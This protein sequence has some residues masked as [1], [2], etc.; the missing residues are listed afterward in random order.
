MCAKGQKSLS[1]LVCGVALGTIVMVANAAK[2]DGSVAG[3][4]AM[5]A[6]KQALHALNRL[7]FGPRPGEVQRVEE[8]GVDKWIE[9]QLH[10]EKLDDSALEARLAPF[11]T[12]RM[13]TR[14]LVENFPPPQMIRAVADGRQ[15]L[16]SN[17]ATRAIY[18]AQMER[19][20]QKDARK[21]RTADPNRDDPTPNTAASSDKDHL[22]VEDDPEAVSRWETARNVDLKLQ[23]LLELPPDERMRAI[24]SMSPD[25]Q[26]ALTGRKS[27]QRQELMEGM[28]PEQKE[29]LS[30]INNPGQVVTSELM[31]AKLL[32]AIYSNRQLEEV[33][34]AFWFNHFNIF[35]NN[36]AD[37]YLVTSYERDVIR[38]HALG[39]FE[40]LLVATAKSPAMLLY[41]DNWVSVGPDSDFAQG[42]AKKH[43]RARQRKRRFPRV[44]HAPGAQNGP[45]KQRRGLNENYARELMELHTLGV[46]G[47]YIQQDVTEVAR[48]L[49]G[50]TIDQPKKGGEF[51]FEARM[52]EPCAKIVLGHKI[53][54]KGE[55]EGLEVLHLL[56]RNPATAR[57]ISSKLAS[58]FVSDNPP[59]ALV[60]RM[61]ETF[62]KKNGDIRE[63]LRTMFRSPEFWSSEAYRAKV[64][65]PLEF[66][67]SAARG[68]DADIQDA[69]ALVR[70]LNTMGMLPYGMQPPT[71]YSTNAQT[72]V[73]S[74][75]LVSRMNFAL[76]LTS[77][78]LKG[79]II[80]EGSNS[81]DFNDPETALK[82]S[83]SALL[84]GDVSSQTHEAIAKQIN[85]GAGS[86]W[87]QNGPPAQK[88][89]AMISGLILGSP[90]FQ[91]R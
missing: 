5:D 33:M 49:T 24:L 66:I 14:E 83:E 51:K 23:E 46:D 44:V 52:H 26:L 85:N 87:R 22:N 89:S 73:T 77:G 57:H 28:S 31:Q 47:G 58:R 80:S 86:K 90:E 53:K 12:L 19:H 11:R 32:R 72:W 3:A 70:I 79:I 88:Q 7:A 37:R 27:G 48:T 50:W 15:K 69:S 45:A 59:P 71:G 74:S 9:T 91:R 43:P 41:L 39:K 17:S 34:T 81:L 6:H 76:A 62:M 20:E 8:M 35:I 1:L 30:A 75:A 10:P 2:R 21:L 65:T 67:A 84:G 78:K 68:T 42:V 13:S 29:T 64:K 63:V 36:G 61:S 55:K 56:A 18:K 4:L 25:E 82:D 60:N 54:E 38:P 16:P 40:D